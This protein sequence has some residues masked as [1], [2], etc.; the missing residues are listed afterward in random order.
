MKR[1]ACLVGLLAAAMS[2]GCHSDIVTTKHLKEL[3]HKCVYIEPILSDDPQVGQVLKDVIEKEFLRKKVALCDE[4]SATVLISGATFMTTRGK[5]SGS[6]FGNSSVT[7]QCCESV[8]ITARDREGNVLLSASYDN[9]D[10]D[11]VSDFG[12]DF[13]AALAGRFR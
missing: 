7:A 4:Q 6:L 5:A 13:G 3:D 8:S 10:R 9:A 12:K 1:C 2:A 11:T